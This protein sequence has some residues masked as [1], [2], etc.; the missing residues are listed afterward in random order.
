MKVLTCWKNSPAHNLHFPPLPISCLQLF[1]GIHSN[2]N[3]RIWNPMEHTVSC[4]E[5]MG[6]RLSLFFVWCNESKKRKWSLITKA[7]YL[8]GKPFL[9]LSTDNSVVE[10]IITM[11]CS[12]L[13]TQ[14]RCRETFWGVVNCL[15]AKLF[16]SKVSTNSSSCLTVIYLASSWAL[17]RLRFNL[18]RHNP[19]EV[20][21]L[22][23]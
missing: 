15:Q 20:Q 12:G 8:K 16:I 4:P 18:A 10:A 14:A 19:L 9:V 22:A 21:K 13:W 17:K 23:Q 5:I 1:V 2:T 11:K 7:R 3:P 6:T